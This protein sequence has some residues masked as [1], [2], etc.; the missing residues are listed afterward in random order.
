[1]YKREC[2]TVSGNVI[3]LMRTQEYSLYFMILLLLA[4]GSIAFC[5]GVGTLLVKMREG[6]IEWLK[7]LE[8][9]LECNSRVQKKPIPIC[10]LE[11]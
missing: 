2:R 7:E 1:M 10:W 8:G 3:I 6:S 5:V 4:L 11:S 9:L